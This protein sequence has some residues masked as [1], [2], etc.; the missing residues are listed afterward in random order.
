LEKTSSHPS[1]FFFP[2]KSKKKKKGLPKKQNSKKK[3]KKSF[4]KKNKF[5]V[6]G[7]K[8][9]YFCF[10]NKYFSQKQKVHSTVRFKKQ[11]LTVLPTNEHQYWPP[12]SQRYPKTGYCFIFLNLFLLQ[13]LVTFLSKSD[14]ILQ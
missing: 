1:L 14:Y 12:L 8:S 6:W 2:K 3:G 13:K 10:Q 11:T 7:W 9:K 5:S 4:F